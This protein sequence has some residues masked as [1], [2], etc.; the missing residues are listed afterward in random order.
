M[1][2]RKTKLEFVANGVS[3]LEMEWASGL[4]PELR[5]IVVQDTMIRRI[6]AGALVCRK[7]EPVTSWMG[8]L[9]GLVRISAPT[10][11][12]GFVS[13]TGVPEGGWFGEGSLLKDEPRR[14]EAVALKASVIAFVPRRT[15]TLLLDTSVT[16]NRYLL[17]QLNERLGQFIGMIERDRSLPPES[18]LASELAALFNPRLYPGNHDSLAISQEELANLVGL[19]RQRAN[20]ALKRLTE[21]GLVHVDYR[22]IRILDLEKLR[23]YRPE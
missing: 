20:R 3:L 17:T 10:P 12:G 13:F 18:R 16:F 2:T 9:S 6:P 15:F 8:V 11:N 1:A 19:S 7:G 5:R 21:A 23:N 14:Y 4:T 22:G